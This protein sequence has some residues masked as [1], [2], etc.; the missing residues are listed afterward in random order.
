MKN[1]K[2]STGTLRASQDFGSTAQD[3]KKIKY[4]FYSLTC[5]SLIFYKLISSNNS[6]LLAYHHPTRFSFRTHDLAL[7]YTYFLTD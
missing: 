5:Y 4:F 2:E 3:F 7:G 6:E 1:N